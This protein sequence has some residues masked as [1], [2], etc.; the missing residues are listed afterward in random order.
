MS[1]WISVGVKLPVPEEEV[2]VATNYGVH[3]DYFEEC[4]WV[5]H[6]FILSADCVITHWMPLPEPPK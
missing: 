2:L 4:N 3:V 1:E 5:W 6:G